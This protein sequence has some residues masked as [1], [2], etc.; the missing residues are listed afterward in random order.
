MQPTGREETLG[1][2]AAVGVREVGCL[3]DH[4]MEGGRGSEGD[5]LRRD[6]TSWK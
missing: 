4:R 5:Y 2:E 3:S 6:T 1:F